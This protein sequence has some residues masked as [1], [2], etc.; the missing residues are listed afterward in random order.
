MRDAVLDLRGVVKR[1]GA[2]GEG[3]GPIDLALG[4]GRTVA[5][6]GPSGAGKST[7]LKLM[8]GLLAPDAGEVRLGGAVLDP[9]DDAGRRRYGFVVQGGGLFPHLS[10]GD[11]ATLVAR[12]LKWDPGRIASR[13]EALRAL[14]RLPAAVLERFPAELS[15]GQAQRVSLV[16]AL[17][18]DPGLLLLDEPLGALDPITRA[19]LQEDLRRVFADL[20]KTV[21]LVT[22][23]LAEAA[24]FADRLVLLRDGRVAQDGSIEDLVRSPADGFVAR[25]VGAHRALRLPEG[26]A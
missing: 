6:I 17:F 4:A 25:F 10:A 7:V 8:L 19:E 20:G 16:R 12:H 5:L 13:L 1:F 21:V 23:D 11:N 3:V 18:L 14:T 26:R 9:R 15:G 24:F 22:H 2:D